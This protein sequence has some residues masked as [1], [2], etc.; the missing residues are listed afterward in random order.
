M[1][2]ENILAFKIL[3]VYF[4]V[5]VIIY[6]IGYIFLHKNETERNGESIAVGLLWPLALLI[7]GGYIFILP[8]IK[9]RDY[10]DKKVNGINGE[11]DE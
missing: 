6:Y 9:F 11:D 5:A 1:H 10:M 8:F 7:G 4:I 3:T 2:P